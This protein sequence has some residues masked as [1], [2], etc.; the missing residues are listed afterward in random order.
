M[1]AS[2]LVHG[3]AVTT[4]FI[5]SAVT[6]YCVNQISQETYSSSVPSVHIYTKKKK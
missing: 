6:L 1:I 3:V 5:F 4:C 2:G